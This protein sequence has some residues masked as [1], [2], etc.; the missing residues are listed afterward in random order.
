M[1]TTNKS[2]DPRPLSVQIT[3]PRPSDRWS[4]LDGLVAD[5]LVERHAPRQSEKK[6]GRLL[7]ILDELAQ[8]GPAR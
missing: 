3:H 4:D 2:L 6:T 1:T 7:A 8:K 5:P